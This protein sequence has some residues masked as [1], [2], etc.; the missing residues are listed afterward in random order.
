VVVLLPFG[1]GLP[2]LPTRW[3][4]ADQLAYAFTRFPYAW[5]NAFNVWTLWA[6][7]TP[8]DWPS[9][10]L[11]FLGL[12]YQTWGALLSAGAAGAMLLRYARRGDDRALVWAC[13][14]LTLVLFMLPTRVHSRYLFPTLVLAA[15]APAIA[16]RLL[17][18]PAALSATF[19]AN[20]LWNYGLYYPLIGLPQR[21]QGEVV[22][23]LLLSLGSVRA[24]R[25]ARERPA[26]AL[27]AAPLARS[28]GWPTGNS[29]IGTD[30]PSVSGDLYLRSVPALSAAEGS[31]A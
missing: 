7:R 16:P 25:G 21:A 15:L 5:L 12:T 13:L 6:M 24:G 3:S 22:N 19:L 4:L 10:A 9:D 23:S 11:T 18:L 28:R 1:M 26:A 8:R 17:W 30:R 31:R 29:R 14:A 27:R 2:L 20:L